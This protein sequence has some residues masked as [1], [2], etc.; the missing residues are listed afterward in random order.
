VGALP[1]MPFC[2]CLANASA[3]RD[4]GTVDA[5]K[6]G[7]Q[8]GSEELVTSSARTYASGSLTSSAWHPILAPYNTSGLPN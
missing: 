5:Q 4:A 8:R 2:V 3:R 1:A 7:F 6:L